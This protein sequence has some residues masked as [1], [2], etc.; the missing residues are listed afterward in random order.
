[1]SKFQYLHDDYHFLELSKRIRDGE[2]VSGSELATYI[3]K[4]KTAPIPDDVMEYVC[5]FLA[6]EVKPPPGRRAIPKSKRLE[7]LLE[8]Q[9]YYTIAK[10]VLNNADASEDAKEWLSFETV[11]MDESMPNHEIA[12]RI[13]ARHT[14]YGEE[15]WRSLLTEISSK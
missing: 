6:G 4:R 8:M 15:S 13:A 10:Y 12:A 7:R 14:H 3:R 11:G 1:M 5:A 9:R 2:F